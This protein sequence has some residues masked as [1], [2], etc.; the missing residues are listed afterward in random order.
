MAFLTNKGPSSSSSS[1]SSSSFTHQNYDIYLSFRGE[2]T[3]NGFTSHLHKALCDKGFNTFI[4]DNLRRG[5]DIS[6]ELLKAIE[7]STISIIIFSKNYASSTWCLDELVKIL[8]CSKLILPIFYNMDPSEVRKQKSEFG[9]ALRKH[10]EI[11]KDDIDKV[12]NWRIAL[13][14]VGSLSGWH[15]KNGETEAKFI[16]KI[17]ENIPK[18]TPIFVGKCLVGVKPRAKAV[19]SLL[20]M[21]LD[22]VCMVVIHGLPGIGKT[23]IAKAIYNRIANHFDGSS[24][25]ENVR[26]TL[27]TKD[28][29]IKLQGQF[30]KEISR[31]ENEEIH[32]TSKGIN[33]IKNRLRSKNVLL[34]L[35]DVDTLERIE[36][37]FGDCNWFT[38]RSRVIITTAADPQL[39]APLGKVYTTY[40]VK[41]LD[42]H[43]ALQLFEKHAFHGKKPNKDY[44]EL[45]NQ[46]IQYAQGLPLAL[47]IIARD[48]CGRPKHEWESTLDKYN[49]IPNEDIQEVLKVS[50]DRLEEIEQDI[51]LDIACF[52]KGWNKD[53][54]VDILNA[55]D[56]HPEYGI[57]R[58]VY[59]CL[60]TVN[61]YG[62]LLMHDLIQQMG[63]E[64][65]RRESPHILGERSRLWHHKDSLD[66]LIGNKG[67]NKIRGIMLRSPQ[68][69]KVPLHAQAFKRMTNLRILI[70]NNLRI[71]EAI[72]YFPNGI[73]FLSWPKYPFPLP[74]NFCPQQLV[75]LHMPESRI[76]L[77]KLCKQEFQLENMKHLN[78]SGCKFIT[79]LPNLCTPN[80]ETLD[81]SYCENLVKIHTSGEFLHKLKTWNLRYCK[82]LQNLPNN[83]MLTSL[84]VLESLNLC[85]CKNLRDLPDGIYKLQLLWELVT[86]TAKLRPTCNSFDSSSGYGFL[87]MKHLNFFHHKNV[88]ELDLLMK[89]DYFPALESIYLSETN[90]ITIPESISRF[91]RLNSLFITDCKHLCEIQ[92]LPL[93]ISEVNAK[94]CPLLDN[95]SPSGLLNQV[96]EIMGI[97]PNGVCGSARSNELMDPQFTDYFSS[98]TEGVESESEGGDIS[99]FSNYFPSEIEGFEYEDGEI[100]R[101]LTISGIEIPWF[102]HQSIEHSSILFWVGRKFPKLAVYI[103]FGGDEEAHDKNDYICECFVYISINGCKKCECMPRHLVLNA[104]N[105]LLLYSPPQRFLQQ[106]LNESNPTDQNLVEVTYKIIKFRQD[107]G[108]FIETLNATRWGVHVECI[109]PPQESGIPN[110]PLLTTGHDDDDDVD[111]WS[112]LPFHGSDDLEAEEDE[113]YQSPLLVH[114]TYE[115]SLVDFY[116]SLISRIEERDVLEQFVDQTLACRTFLTKIVNFSLDYFDKDLG[117]V[118]EKLTTALKAIEVAGLYDHQA[119]RNLELALARY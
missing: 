64:V 78:L 114:M 53:Y 95:E 108:A 46:V 22:E 74:S 42:K 17:V 6:I 61:Q 31:D 66:V 38:S 106:K 33:L 52:F 13:N 57:Q 11:F 75:S 101:I 107:D 68:W 65:A 29:I 30:L 26:E 18:C 39:L 24:F 115:F 41:E 9:V 85:D 119:N 8:E 100:D 3:R 69:V 36:K 109:C 19:E 105:L 63:R 103:A 92:G 56:S 12:Q 71:C 94:N 54:V 16:Q 118:S 28:G 99:Q 98:E 14:K 37:L 79:K 112:E 7:S 73:R 47:I 51:F 91:P 23:T 21:G 93:S 10:E 97:L 117:A 96:I 58:L 5:E 45:T 27:E 88:I 55:S 48:L 110:L 72:Q 60:V 86:P 77:E 35:D 40:K 104:Y 76:E 82:K 80:L 49:K 44:Y 111:Y 62:T 25:L 83:L 70:V 1:S 87:K 116:V 59:K 89:P 90:I 67:S 15:Y 2:D 113:D 81:L 50:Y 4:D 102:N 32:S 43:E 34:V 84:E 20:S